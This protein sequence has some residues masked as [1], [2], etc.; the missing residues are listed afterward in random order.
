MSSKLQILSDFKT[1]LVGFLDELIQ[2]F[3]EE[4]DLIVL[5]IFLADQVP[6]EEIMKTFCEKCLP[7]KDVI[8]RRDQSF[9]LS[10][11]VL[12]EKIDQNKVN[13]FKK[14][15]TSPKLD[16]DDRCVIWAW[17]DNFVALSEKYQKIQA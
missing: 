9:F 12:F 5:R 17:Y 13:H 10:N 6:T 7:L 1:S 15:W 14:L 3:P 8:K 4:G 16:D 11:N 2:Q